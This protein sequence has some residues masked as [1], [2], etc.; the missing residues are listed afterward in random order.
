MFDWPGLTTPGG[1]GQISLA[2]AN[3]TYRP[4]VRRGSGGGSRSS[5]VTL[6]QCRT[7]RSGLGARLGGSSRGH[8]A[9]GRASSG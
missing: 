2:S 9:S 1:P 8:S 4:T 5:D 7:S 3:A 6:T